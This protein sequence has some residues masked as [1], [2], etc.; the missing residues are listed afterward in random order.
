MLTGIV[1]NNIKMKWQFNKKKSAIFPALAGKHN[2]FSV[3]E[4][5]HSSYPLPVFVILWL[6]YFILHNVLTVCLCGSLCQNLL[7]SWVIFHSID[8][9]HILLICPSTNR[10]LNHFHLLA[11]ENNAAMNIDMQTSVCLPAFNSFRYI[12]G[13]GIAGSYG[14]AI[15]HF[16]RNCHMV[17][18]SSGPIYIPTS[19]EQGF[20]FLC[21]LDNIYPLFFFFF[22]CLFSCFVKS[23]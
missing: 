10:H 5:H 14:N 7:L 8:I 11:L 16:L 12:P 3:S 18:R 15:F 20:Q 21:I 9:D 6:V 1:Q 22:C 2:L 17:F 4:F 19:S 13:T 23:S